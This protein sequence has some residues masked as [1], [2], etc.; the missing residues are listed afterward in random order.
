M[1]DTSRKPR[2]QL[3]PINNNIKAD[4]VQVIGQD[5]G[6]LG[7][8]P[9]HEAISIA[10]AAELDLVLIAPTGK[11][12]VPVTK[13]MDYGKL[14]Y[15]KKKKQTEAKK[16]QSVIQVKEIKVRPKIGEHDF[17]TKIKQA[18]SFLK[19][20]KHVKMTLQFRGREI[21]TRQERGTDMF[22]RVEQTFRELEVGNFAHEKEAKQGPF[23]SRV[24]FVK[25]K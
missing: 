17:Q 5:G 12:D 9:L 19:E 24:Y 22:E 25:S 14:L 11:D 15:E 6:N 2:P 7:V 23:W 1:N 16:H 13:I 18:A 21:T 4:M 3:P 20:G 8:L 10:R